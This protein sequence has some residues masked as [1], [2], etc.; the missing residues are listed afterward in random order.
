MNALSAS[1]PRGLDP[2]MSRFLTPTFFC[3]DYLVR[4]R[5]NSYNFFS[6]LF[7]SSNVSIEGLAFFVFVSGSLLD[8]HQLGSSLRVTFE[9]VKTFSE[10]S[11]TK[12]T[13]SLP[14]LLLLS[15]PSRPT[16]IRPRKSLSD[17]RAAFSG[18]IPAIVFL[19]GHQV[20][21]VLFQIQSFRVVALEGLPHFVGHRCGVLLHHI[22][23]VHDLL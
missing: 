10:Q 1:C 14:P 15:P 7:S 22:L 9:F 17:T 13:L 23:L 5:A 8:A 16:F 2:H 20:G 4:S 6:T 12:G 3:S 19:R 21:Q 18:F 11:Q